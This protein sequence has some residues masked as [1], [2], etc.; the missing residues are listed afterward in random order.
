MVAIVHQALGNVLSLHTCGTSRRDRGGGEY[1]RGGGRRVSG[2]T[3]T[4]DHGSKRQ[5]RVADM[6][7]YWAVQASEPAGKQAQLQPVGCTEPHVRYMFSHVDVAWNSKVSSE[8]IHLLSA[9]EAS[10]P[11]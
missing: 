2:A 1:R 4:A 6:K 10:H 7:G 5:V 8:P 11:G 3:L 9:P